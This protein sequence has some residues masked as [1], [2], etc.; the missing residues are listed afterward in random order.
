MKQKPSLSSSTVIASWA[1]TQLRRLD[2]GSQL[3]QFVIWIWNP[4][5]LHLKLKWSCMLALATYNLPPRQSCRATSLPWS[6][7]LQPRCYFWHATWQARIP[8][9]RSTAHPDFSSRVVWRCEREKRGGTQSGWRKLTLEGSR[10]VQKLCKFWTHLTRAA[11]NWS[12]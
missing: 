4:R 12:V 7:I 6:V 8:S 2:W 1:D 5:Q 9:N 10:A 3:D 11:D